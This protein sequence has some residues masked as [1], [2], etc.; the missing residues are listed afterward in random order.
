MLA[1][2]FRE[3]K[4]MRNTHTYYIYIH[5]LINYIRF[6][7]V[8][9]WDGQSFFPSWGWERCERNLGGNVIYDASGCMP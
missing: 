4:H 2:R 8:F 9:V 1:E 5:N 7:L 6:C 3:K